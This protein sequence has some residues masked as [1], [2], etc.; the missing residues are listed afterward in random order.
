VSV[1]G[2]LA[3]RRRENPCDRGNEVNG[4][5]SGTARVRHPTARGHPW[6]RVHERLFTL[7]TV[8][9]VIEKRMAGFAFVDVS[10]W[11]DLRCRTG[12]T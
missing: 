8:S 12:P 5:A 10:I 2:D 1:H 7:A 11:N 4:N 9:P 3:Q 6:R